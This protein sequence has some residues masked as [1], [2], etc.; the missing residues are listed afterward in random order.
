MVCSKAERLRIFY[1]RLMGAAPA[2]GHDEAVLLFE[3]TLNGV[4]DEM[5]GTPFDL[6]N[7]PQDG[8]M[9]PPLADRVKPHRNASGL[10]I[11]TRRFSKLHITYTA[12][13]GAISIVR[14]ENGAVELDKPGRDGRLFGEL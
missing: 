3:A 5:S 1:T 14:R 9:Y 11:G 2:G 4:E 6:A 10:Q 13:N 8:R 7:S 12:E